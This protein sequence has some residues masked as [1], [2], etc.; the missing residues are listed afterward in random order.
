M[1]NTFKFLL[2]QADYLV[3]AKKVLSSTLAGMLD[4]INIPAGL[5]SCDW[6]NSC[7][8]TF[9]SSYNSIYNFNFHISKAPSALAH[10]IF[11]VPSGSGKTT[12]AL[13]LIDGCLKNFDIDIYIFD[14]FAGCE[15]FTKYKNHTLIDFDN[16]SINPL[17][18]DLD[19]EENKLFLNNFL[20]MLADAQDALDIQIINNFV[21]SIALLDYSDRKL[22]ELTNSLIPQSKVKDNMDKWI[23]GKYSSY[24]SELDIS[25]DDD[26]MYTFS[27]EKILDN[28]DLAPIIYFMMF[29]IQQKAKKTGRCHF[30]FIDEAAA[31]LKNPYFKDK[32][33]ILLQEHRKLRGAKI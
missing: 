28:E 29:K 9:N 6:G 5:N 31:M 7:I 20:T 8:T 23:N 1:H 10:G 13:Y 2:P 25:L 4:Y 18:L 19:I 22:K 27:M 30:I 14:R 11:V 16:Q 21:N 3:Y 26:N 33:E 24:I 15:I 12:L 17:L 32:I